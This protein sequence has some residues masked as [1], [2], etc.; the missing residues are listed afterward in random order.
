MITEYERDLDKFFNLAGMSR[1]DNYSFEHLPNYT[2]INIS[3]Q[4]R[5]GLIYDLI[6]DADKQALELLK[7]EDNKT[8]VL[9]NNETVSSFHV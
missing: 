3:N 8:E 5:K 1:P 9:D 7:N 6:Q 4:T 2:E